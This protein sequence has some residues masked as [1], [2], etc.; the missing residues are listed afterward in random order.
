M[1][2]I[3]HHKPVNGPFEDPTVFVRILG[4]KRALL[5]DAGDVSGL[6]ARDLMKVTD[7]F[8]THMHIDHFIGFDT[9]I[10]ALLRRDSPVTFYGPAGII[11][12][13]EGKLRGYTWNLISEYPLVINVVE[14]RNKNVHKAT[15]RAADKFELNDQGTH[16]NEGSVLDNSLFSVNA[17]VLEHDVPSLG[18]SIK[19]KI[20]INIDKA[21]LIDCGFEVGPWLS[22][23]KD[24]IRNG[25]LHEGI[26]TGKGRYSVSELKNI[27]VMTEGQKVSY[28]MDSSPTESNFEKIANFVVDADS[29]YIEAYFIHEDLEHARKR[30]HLTARLSGLISKKARVKNL[31]LLHFSP[32]YKDRAEDIINEAYE[33]FRR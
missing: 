7:V 14:I 9:I 12:R 5:F 21:K 19:E 27:Y 22:T 23:L 1:K 26:D 4:E 16:N 20:H 3:F 30:N 2:P 6:P 29:L 11:D 8:V 28:I 18:F 31:H 24:F 32:R 25:K 17:V 13:I 10:R 33:G 15:F